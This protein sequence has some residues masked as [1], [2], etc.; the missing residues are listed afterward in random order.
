MEAGI[1]KQKKMKQKTYLLSVLLLAIITSCNSQIEENEIPIEELKFES[2][3]GTID[4]TSKEVYCLLGQGFFRSPNSDDSD[5]LIANWLNKHQSAKLVKIS[6]IHGDD[7]SMIYSMVIDGNENLN[8]YLVRNGCFPGGTM[9]R[10]ETWEEMGEAER[11]I[12]GDKEERDV[13]VLIDAKTY[14]KYFDEIRKA[15]EI[16]ITEKL[17]I[18]EDEL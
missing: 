18:W 1:S 5:S 17:G 3:F 10:P 9:E 13:E 6:I 4:E 2:I 16:A 11:K 12:Y 8:V 14:K 7:Q 15:E